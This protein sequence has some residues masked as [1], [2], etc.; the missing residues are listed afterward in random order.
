MKSQVDKSRIDQRRALVRRLQGDERGSKKLRANTNVNVNE[1]L[2]EKLCEGP[3][4]SR[5]EDERKDC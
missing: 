5:Q 4:G 2:Q 3:Q 1:G